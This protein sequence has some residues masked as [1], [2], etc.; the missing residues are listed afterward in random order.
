M[1]Y[2]FNFVIVIPTIVVIFVV[3]IIIFY[4]D[5]LD[6]LFMFL[7]KQWVSNKKEV[8][9]YKCNYEYYC[10]CIYNLHDQPSSLHLQTI[11]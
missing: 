5:I 11:A 3:V 1:N 4:G 9:L 2:F 10:R 8:R 6:I 7:F